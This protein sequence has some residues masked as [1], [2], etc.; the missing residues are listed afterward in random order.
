MFLN[1]LIGWDDNLIS[2]AKISENN[3]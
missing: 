1:R 2:Y 3:L